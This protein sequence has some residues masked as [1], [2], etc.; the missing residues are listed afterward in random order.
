MSRRVERAIK[1]FPEYLPLFANNIAETCRKLKISRSTYQKLYNENKEFKE[2]IDEVTE[3]V[4]DKV[5]CSLLKS[6]DEGNV[7]AQ[8]FFLKNKARHRGYTENEDKSGLTQ[9]F[10]IM[11]DDV[12]QIAAGGEEEV[13]VNTGGR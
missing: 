5:E 9:N 12:K 11:I 6:A 13:I 1:R 4:V 10:R 8:I 3:E 2:R 7:Q